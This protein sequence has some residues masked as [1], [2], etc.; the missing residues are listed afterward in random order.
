MPGIIHGGQLDEDRRPPC[1]RE[2]GRRPEHE[3]R[4]SDTPRPHD[5]DQALPVDQVP[6]PH[7]FM[8]AADHRCRRSADPQAARGVRRRSR[9]RQIAQRHLGLQVGE[10]RAGVEAGGFCQALPELVRGAEGIGLAVRRGQRPD[11]QRLRGLTERR[12]R[13]GPR[14]IAHDGD[15]VVAP[16]E[17]GLDPGVG[18]LEA[19]LGQG[20]RLGRERRHVGELVQRLAAPGGQCLPQQDRRVGPT[21]SSGAL[22]QPP[23][24]GDVERSAAEVEVVAG[25]VA[26]QPFGRRAEVLA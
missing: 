12:G 16:R 1:L 6:Q 11:P 5:R 26:H 25:R 3:A 19:E 22:G 20:D 14:G 9:G 10:G 17:P 13:R 18:E 15:G 7:R 21:V 23:H 24:V 8:L 4:L 2:L